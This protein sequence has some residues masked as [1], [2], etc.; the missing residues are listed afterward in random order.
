MRALAAALLTYWLHS[1]VLLSLAA[2]TCVVLRRRHLALQETLLRTALLA[3]FVSASLQTGF[4]LRCFGGSFELTAAITPARVVP[5]ARAGGARSDVHHGLP[6]PAALTTVLAPGADDA[7]TLPSHVGDHRTPSAMRSPRPS[8]WA[9][10]WPQ[11]LVGAWVLLALHAL[12]RLARSASHLRALLR[13]R[14]PLYTGALSDCAARLARRLGLSRRVRLSLAPRLDVPLARGLWRPEV[15]LPARALSELGDDERTA[16][17][18]HELAHVVR[19][20][21]AWLLLARLIE[22]LAPL[23]PLNLWARRRLQDVA[24]CLSDDLAVE[25]CERPLGLARCL[26]DVAGWTVAPTLNPV[27]AAHASGV[28]SHLGHRVERLMDELRP[29][30]RPRRLLLPLTGAILLATAF[31]PSVFSAGASA[32]QAPTAVLPPTATPPRPPA[33]PR[34]VLAPRARPA[35]APQAAP[36]P[37]PVAQPAPV[38]DAE[39]PDLVDVEVDIHDGPATES[40]SAEVEKLAEARDTRDAARQKQLAERQAHLE[41]RLEHL[42]ERLA[43]HQE[44]LEALSTRLAEASVALAG[45]KD[46]QTRAERRAQVD[47][48]RRALRARADQMRIP[49]AEIEQL[50]REARAL[51]EQ[52]RPS[53]REL[54]TLRREVERAARVD[55]R[56]INAQ[57]RQELQAARVE[58]ERAAAEM[59]RAAEELRQQLRTTTPESR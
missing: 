28:R 50:A 15:C 42:H 32:P 35:A 46:A 33:S 36:V 34:A 41:A 9:Q 13:D 21:P 14:S 45:A 5:A 12:L 54:R 44:Q 40:D 2:L 52:A 47:Q 30:E 6:G 58:F 26:V 53:E 4:G 16:L 27:A 24:E 10:A 48:A 20:D 11:W 3:G 25:A 56:G 43:P 37:A 19:R 8:A 29:L 23:Q 55:V 1:S 22:A 31:V 39:A 51:A 57:V 59:R 18:A 17:C 49:H 38:T 7:S